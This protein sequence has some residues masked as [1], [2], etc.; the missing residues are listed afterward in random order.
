MDKNLSKKLV[1]FGAATLVKWM[2]VRW[3]VKEMLKDVNP[4]RS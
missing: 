1:I 2:T 3:V 4:D